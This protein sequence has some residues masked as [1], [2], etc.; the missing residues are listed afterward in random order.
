MMQTLQI[1]DRTDRPDQVFDLSGWQAATALYDFGVELRLHRGAARVRLHHHPVDGPARVLA[2][3]GPPEDGRPGSTYT[4]PLVL[5]D[6]SGHIRPELVEQSADAEFDLRFISGA[7]TVRPHPGL[8][9]LTLLPEGGLALCPPGADGNAPPAVRLEIPRGTGFGAGLWHLAFG[10]GLDAG[11]EHVCLQTAG[12]ALGPAALDRMQ[13]MLRYLRPGVHLAAPGLTRGAEGWICLS[14]ADLA[15]CGLPWPGLDR[16]PALISEQ[17]AAALGPPIAPASL[18]AAPTPMPDLAPPRPEWPADAL[19]GL[20]LQLRDRGAAA[21]AAA[22]AAAVTADLQAGATDRAAGR[23]DRMETLLGGAERVFDALA[24]PPLSP[25]RPRGPLARW[26][27]RRR[28]QGQMARMTAAGQGLDAALCGLAG[29]LAW[30]GRCQDGAGQ[31][32]TGQSG[33]GQSGTGVNLPAADR[34][35]LG[36]QRQAALAAAR[37]AQ[38][39]AAEADARERA[40][41]IRGL[42]NP[43][44]VR[45]DL[46]RPNRLALSALRNV[47]A[48]RRCVIVGNGPSLRIADLDRLRGEITFGSNKIFLAYDQT[49]WRPTYYSVEDHLVLRNCQA[50]IAA[51]QGSFKIFPAQMR[52]FG[53]HAADTLFVPLLPPLSF[54]QPLSDPDFPGFSTDLAHGIR[55]GSTVVYSQIQMAVHMGCTEIVL[56]GLDHRYDLPDRKLGRVYVDAGERNHFHPDYRQPGEL[57][58]QPNLDVLEVSYTRAR[59]VC[60]ARGIAIRNASRDSALTVFDRVDFDTLFPPAPTADGAAP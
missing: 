20:L 28:L 41:H 36:L 31:S 3:L 16:D 22:H 15:R 18:P 50:E 26:R 12:A 17:L 4:P 45:A 21:L 25:V 8:C 30:A 14:L 5:A 48:G 44:R 52:D 54:A 34:V 59:E 29:P 56:I 58:H 51:L 10:P 42:G 1:W 55:W 57:W 7:P 40:L 24:A 2:E 35:L 47:H 27:L 38:A 11:V 60:A 19:P 33:T 49:G 37:M 6:H 53:H 9:L 43:D 39:L 32:R 46:E 13:A 23:L